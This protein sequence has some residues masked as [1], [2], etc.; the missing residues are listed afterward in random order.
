MPSTDDPVEKKAPEKKAEEKKEEKK[1]VK[2]KETPKVTEA[3]LASD[4]RSVILDIHKAVSDI[5]KKTTDFERRLGALEE[6]LAESS[7]ELKVLRISV[8]KTLPD[9]EETRTI[10]R[11]ASKE[12]AGEDEEIETLTPDMMRKIRRASRR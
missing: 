1:V 11:Q 3:E 7:N 9:T 4:V 5:N 6:E 12:Q 8:F 2:K 10:H